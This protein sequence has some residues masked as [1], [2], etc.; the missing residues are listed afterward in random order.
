MRHEYSKWKE[1]V[2]RKKELALLRHISEFLCGFRSSCWGCLHSTRMWHKLQLRLTNL[3]RERQLCQHWETV[4]RLLL[5]PQLTGQHSDVCAQAAE[6]RNFYTQKYTK[7]PGLRA[8]FDQRG[9]IQTIAVS[10]ILFLPRSTVCFNLV[11]F[12]VGFVSL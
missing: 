5:Q 7:I 4:P 1:K 8:V 9:L 2:E 10:S 3:S 6:S 11:L 12:T